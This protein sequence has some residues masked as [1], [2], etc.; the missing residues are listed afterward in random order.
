MPG[1]KRC[2]ILVNPDG[3]LNEEGKPCALKFEHEGAHKPRVPIVV[4]DDDLAAITGSVAVVTDESA[5]SEARRTRT[6]DDSPLSKMAVKVTQGAYDAWVRGGKHTKWEDTPAIA[7]DVPVSLES[8]MRS[9]IH[10]ACAVAKR[11]A[12]FGASKPVGEDGKFVKIF[13]QVRDIPAKPADT[14]PAATVPAVAPPTEAQNAVAAAT[15]ARRS[16]KG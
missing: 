13:F 9:A 8:K 16:A 10:T 14:A 7:L 6:M 3:T 11:R 15:A 12:Q 2:G 4:S 5:L 1:V